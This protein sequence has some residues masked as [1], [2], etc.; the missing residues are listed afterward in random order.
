MKQVPGYEG[1]SRLAL[2]AARLGRG[3]CI[4][5]LLFALE[6]AAAPDVKPDFPRLGKMA[7]GSPQNYGDPAVQAALAKLDYVVID[8]HA[9]W[10]IVSKMQAALR[11]IK[12]INQKIIIAD[13]VMLGQVNRTSPA[14]KPHRDKLDQEGWWLYAKATGGSKVVSID[15]SG[16][17]T[18]LT[19]SV[20]TDANGDR[21]N[22]WMAKRTYADMWSHLPELDGVYTDNV[23]W[24]PRAGGDWDRNGT[25]DNLQAAA[26][27]F[28]AGMVKHFEQLRAL[29]PAKLVTGNIGD[30]G[31]PEASVPEYAGK[32]DGG[33]LEHYI[34]MSWSHEG[35]DMNGVNNGWGSW[36]RM[37]TAY[38][39]VSGLVKDPA[40]M[41]FNM[42]GKSTDF[43][44]FRYGFASSLM[45]DAYFDFSDGTSG[46]VYKPT[47]PW[48]NEYD[49]AG[50][51]TTSW[52]GRAVDQP[53]TAPWKDGVYRR[54]FENGMALV[55]PRGNGPRSVAVGPGF[56]RFKGKQDPAYNNGGPA[57]TVLL[58]DRD[59]ILLVK[60]GPTTPPPPPDL[61]RAPGLNIIQ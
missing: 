35:V 11:A 57:E 3:A 52:L 48:F 17:I 31:R 23:F 61:L 49:L 16:W 41:L 6:A 25:A 44:T 27:A 4:G 24:K 22:R 42:K 53:Q 15:G 19:D 9:G 8:F 58:A 38:R 21:W 47:V 34:G 59:G 40:L 13:Y 51:K 55:N 28:R 1:L 26:P 7:I 39:K 43:K 10:G 14:V 20:P 37:M 5:M 29:V 32:L 54:R 2:T 60:S 45:G 18:N 50:T 56:A 33:F 12:A 36:G 30:W 46:S